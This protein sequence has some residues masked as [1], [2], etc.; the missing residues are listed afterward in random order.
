VAQSI[1]FDFLEEGVLPFD[2]AEAK[3]ITW[4]ESV[5]LAEAK[6]IAKLQYYFC[7]DTQ[8]LDLNLQ[9]L[10][11]DTL[12]DIIT[13]PY[14]TNPIEAEIYISLDRV[15]ENAKTYSNGDYY[16]ELNRVLVHGLL[17]MCGYNDHSLEEKEI[18]H[19]KESHYLENLIS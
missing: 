18:I 3:I 16:L 17:H 11:H 9:Y 19:D 7:S 4:L 8:L 15:M 14:D 6:S 12:T 1:I 5:A 10:Q 13:F 2:F